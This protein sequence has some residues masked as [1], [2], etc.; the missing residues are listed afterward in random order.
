MDGFEAFCR[1]GATVESESTPS[2]R[3]LLAV[4]ESGWSEA[5][6]RRCLAI[7]ASRAR[8]LARLELVRHAYQR[9]LE[10]WLLL[11]QCL[12]LEEQ[13]YA[14]ELRQ[15]CETSVSPRNLLV[16]GQRGR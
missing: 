14:V 11:D 8:R 13:G 10:Q 2:R 4:L 5:E 15:F 16:L 7:G 12:Y 9:P 6:A 3:G 1:W